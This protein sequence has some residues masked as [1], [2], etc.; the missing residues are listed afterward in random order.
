[1]KN[2]G[3]CEKVKNRRKLYW[4]AYLIMLSIHPR[5]S[6]LTGLYAHNHNVLTNKENCSSPEWI[7]EHEPHTFA[8]YMRDAGYRTGKR[9]PQVNLL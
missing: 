6:M 7:R 2:T 9:Q 5:S 8:T 1:M 3:G 4:L